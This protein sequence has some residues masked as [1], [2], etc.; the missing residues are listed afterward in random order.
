VRTIQVLAIV[1]DPVLFSRYV[2]GNFFLAILYTISS[3]LNI[4]FWIVIIAVIVSWIPLDPYHPLAR[5][6]L[7]FLRNV[8]E[9]VFG[10]FRRTFRLHRYTAPLDFTPMIV[11]LL[12]FVIQNV[13]IHSL[14]QQVGILFFQ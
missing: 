12:I 6:I 5:A 10:F 11:I 3:V 7:T 4:Y 9:P 14:L 2:I 8:T 1:G 13:V